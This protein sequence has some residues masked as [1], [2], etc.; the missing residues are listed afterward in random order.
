[1]KKV[2]DFIVYSNLFIAV[3]CALFTLQTTLIFKE[4]NA[5]IFNYTLINF[6]ATFC[7]YNFQRLYYS[8]TQS[9]TTKYDWYIK[10]RR[11]VFTLIVLLV[12]S[13]FNFLWEFF[14]ENKTHLIVYSLLS[15]TSLLYFLPPIQLKKYGMFKPFIISAIFV[16]I[17]ILIPLNFKMTQQVVFY[18]FAQ[19]FFIA[20]LCVLF[21][22]RD[23]EADKE[24]NIHTLPVL[25]GIKKTKVIAVT[26]LCFYLVFSIL[27]HNKEFALASLFIFFIS[28]AIALFTNYTRHNFFYLL[29]VDGL[30]VVQFFISVYFENRL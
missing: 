15:I 18:S 24:K 6:I 4:T 8:A 23:L 28:V 21:D 1:M 27:L 25:L 11:L 19:L 13:S 9:K 3:C 2:L 5:I 17:A 22:I 20:A 30:I 14:V 12:V 26:L 16:V 7:L 10:N 29:I